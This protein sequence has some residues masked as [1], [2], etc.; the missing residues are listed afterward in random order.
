MAIENKF[1]LRLIEGTNAELDADTTVYA[2]NVFLYATDTDVLK[3]GDG[4]NAYADLSQF[5]QGVDA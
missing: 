5:N 1:N 4:T 3:K 2:A